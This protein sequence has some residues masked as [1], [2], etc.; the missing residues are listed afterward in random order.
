MLPSVEN[1]HFQVSPIDGSGWGAI[2]MDRESTVYGYVVHSSPAKAL[3]RAVNVLK[4][5]EPLSRLRSDL[6][7]S[8]DSYRLTLN[9]TTG[10]A[11]S[12]EQV[13]YQLPDRGPR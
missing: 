6:T 13:E 4:G 11:V 9:A 8:E 1:A 2:I 12:L 7:V 3:E 10:K 5:V